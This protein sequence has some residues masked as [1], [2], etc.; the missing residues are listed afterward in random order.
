MRLTAVVS[1]DGHTYMGS[2]MVECPR[3]GRV[4]A[5]KFAFP[6]A[7]SLQ[8]LSCTINEATGTAANR[9]AGGT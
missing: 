1:L 3:L 7:G 9:S 6:P 4:L 8:W 2:G 5:E